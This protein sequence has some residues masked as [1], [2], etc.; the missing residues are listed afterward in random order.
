MKRPSSIIGTG[1]DLNFSLN[2]EEYT[3]LANSSSSVFNRESKPPIKMEWLNS[4][5]FA[6]LTK[7]LAK[8]LCSYLYGSK[9]ADKN[10]MS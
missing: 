2:F 3:P 1:N 7:A 10:I 9:N 6:H 4:F 8:D 5:F